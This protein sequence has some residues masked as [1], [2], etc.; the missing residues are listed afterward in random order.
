[1]L[2]IVETVLMILF[3]PLP[4][5]NILL[6]QLGA[7]VCIVWIRFAYK[8]AYWGNRWHSCWYRKNASKTSDEPSD[9]VVGYTKGLGY[10]LLLLLQFAFLV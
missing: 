3:K 7:I 8:I 2:S 6:I 9:L 5:L 10:F 4:L 1:M